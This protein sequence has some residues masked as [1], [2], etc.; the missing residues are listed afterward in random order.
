M[1]DPEAKCMVKSVDQCVVL[2]YGQKQGQVTTWLTIGGR[3]KMEYN[4]VIE[5]VKEAGGKYV[6]L[7]G[8]SN[9]FPEMR[10]IAQGLASIG[11][12]VVINLGQSDSV[13]PFRALR[14]V[15]CILHITPPS[16]NINEVN[17]KNL[18]LLKEDDDLF[19]NIMN[20]EE[21]VRAVDFITSV[22]IT[23]PTITLNFIRAAGITEEDR[24]IISKISDT[25]KI[26]ISF[27]PAE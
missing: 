25:K 24:A 22:Q 5:K 16:E 7:S 18:P 1:I 9:R 11:Y 3:V 15:R 21:L 23:R 19:I 10:D 14:M 8:E 12:S 27:I 17:Y 6:V 13:E 26:R 2:P 20:T 4:R